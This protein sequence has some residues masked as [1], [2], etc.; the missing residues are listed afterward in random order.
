MVESSFVSANHILYLAFDLGHILIFLL[1]DFHCSVK[2][3]I[4]DSVS[5]RF[6]A[7]L[8]S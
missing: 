4:R 3:E 7:G 6:L 5:F 2:L 1:K 8:Q